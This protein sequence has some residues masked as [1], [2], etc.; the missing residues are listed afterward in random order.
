MPDGSIRTKQTKTPTAHA[1]LMSFEDFRF[2]ILTIK[3]MFQN[4]RTIAPIKPSVAIIFSTN[5]PF[6]PQ[7]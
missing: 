6:Y 7:P 3:G 1:K 4:G 5:T 2:P